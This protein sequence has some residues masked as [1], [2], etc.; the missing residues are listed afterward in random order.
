MFA[1]ALLRFQGRG[2][3][4]DAAEGAKLFEQAANLGHVGAAY[5]LG[6]L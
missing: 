4:R 6:L 2:G 3:P 5:N 1:L